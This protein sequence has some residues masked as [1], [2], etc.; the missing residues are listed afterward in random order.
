[1]I[2]RLDFQA[3]NLPRGQRGKCENIAAAEGDVADCA[4]ITGVAGLRMN[5]HTGITGITGV[6]APFRKFNC[7]TTAPCLPQTLIE[8]Y[9][10]T[11][12]TGPRITLDKESNV[13]RDV[14]RQVYPSRAPRGKAIRGYSAQAQASE[15]SPI[16]RGEA[17][18]ALIGK[19][20]PRGRNQPAQP[21]I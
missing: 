11:I 14:V 8:R 10:S 15:G 6:L 13:L 7:H 16:R 20:E 2:I 21:S 1:F 12:R 17:A 4:P 19:L 5:A 3:D 9:C 18:C